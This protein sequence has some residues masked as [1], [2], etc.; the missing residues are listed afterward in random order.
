MVV[1]V[2]GVVVPLMQQPSP[3]QGLFGLGTL[4][5]VPSSP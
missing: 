5:D 4:H 2:E 3:V 1:S